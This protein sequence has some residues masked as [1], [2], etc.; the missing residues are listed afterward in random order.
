MA[1]LHDLISALLWHGLECQDHWVA[2]SRGLVPAVHA[3]D[4]FVQLGATT[5][6]LHPFSTA[7]N[8]QAVD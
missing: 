8:A 3:V 6:I 5:F 4:G 7:R 2:E 1:Y